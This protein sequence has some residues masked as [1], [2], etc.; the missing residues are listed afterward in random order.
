MLL[1]GNIAEGQDLDILDL[2]N[3][4]NREEGADDVQVGGLGALLPCPPSL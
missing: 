4:L 2:P 3:V 1:T